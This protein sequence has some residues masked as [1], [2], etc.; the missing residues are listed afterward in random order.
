MPLSHLHQ[1]CAVMLCTLAVPDVC[2]F[3]WCIVFLLVLLK[4]SDVGLVGDPLEK[5]AFKAINFSF[6]KGPSTRPSVP[7]FG[8]PSMPDVPL[9]R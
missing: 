4:N 9:S 7:L 5:V 3:V 6:A 8:Q 2:C 1:V